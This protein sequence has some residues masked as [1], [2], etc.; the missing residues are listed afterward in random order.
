MATLDNMPSKLTLQLKKLGKLG[1]FAG[2][3]VMIMTAGGCKKAV[4]APPPTPSDRP[5]AEMVAEAEQLYAQR[6]DLVKVRQA[7]IIL[8]QAMVSNSTNYDIAWKLA[9]FNYYLGAHSPDDGEKEKAFHDGIEAGKL[10]VQLNNDKPDGHFWLGANYGGNAE[11]STLA[12]LSDIEDIQR[13]METVIKLDEGYEAGSAYLGLG[14]TFLKAPRLLGGNTD[15]AIG[16]LE[17]GVKIG[18][19]NGLLRVRLA[20]AYAQANRNDDA[21]KQIEALLAIKPSPGYEPEYNDAVAQARKL[22]DKIK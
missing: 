4:E 7:L 15:K 22:Q 3:I 17:K 1:I 9:K 16:Y 19:N 10:A 8:R 21:R 5:A 14:Q 18:P 12:G 13:E 6:S 20:E 2:G 11:I